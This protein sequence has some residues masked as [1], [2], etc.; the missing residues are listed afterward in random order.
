MS[1]RVRV[2]RGTHDRETADL[3]RQLKAIIINYRFGVVNRQ[4]AMDKARALI[5]RQ[6]DDLLAIARSRVHTA[7]GRRVELPP[8]E[9]RRMER[10][11]DEYINDFEGILSDVK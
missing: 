10:W 3:E 8:E 6:F 2:A 7:T 9:R 11:R 5:N 1:R 4:R